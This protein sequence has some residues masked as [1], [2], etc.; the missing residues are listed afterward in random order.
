[1]SWQDHYRK[2]ADA[3]RVEAHAWATHGKE[4]HARRCLDIAEIYDELIKEA[5]ENPTKITR[6]EV[7]KMLEKDQESNG[8]I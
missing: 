2:Q 3:W 6:A 1:M 8:K 5:E 7:Q 4:G